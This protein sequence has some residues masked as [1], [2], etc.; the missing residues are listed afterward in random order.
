M[1]KELTDPNEKN[2]LE[3]DNQFMKMKLMLEYN[4]KFEEKGEGEIPPEIENQFLKQVM[5][6]EKQFAEHKVVKVFDKIGK[7]TQFRPVGE[8]SDEDIPGAWEELRD[9][10]FS[11]Q[12]VLD[13][14]SPN[15]KEKELYRFV[16]EELFDCEVDDI[17]LP[18][19]FTNFI[20]D[21][22]YPDHTYENP[23][24]IK[25]HILPDIF[26]KEPLFSGYG[27]I[28]NSVVINGKEYPG[29]SE[30]KEHLDL[31]KS[32]YNEIS[33]ASCNILTCEI[34]ENDSVLTGNYAA[35]LETDKETINISGNIRVIMEL[36]TFGYYAVKS[37]ELENLNI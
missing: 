21:E 35:E 14:C 16:T 15:V 24:M 31:F 37:L 4:A 27:Y 22:F 36:N 1:A 2:D 6:F 25:D 3:V 20:Y 34:N 29:F 12:V 9:Y 8:L 10:M 33:L 19:F 28:D 13:H 30:L 23:N 32:A 7:P 17:K 11:H 18:G 26:R 5:E